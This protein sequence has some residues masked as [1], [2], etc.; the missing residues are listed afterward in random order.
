MLNLTDYIMNEATFNDLVES[1][2]D[3]INEC[4]TTKA[5]KALWRK[6][7]KDC[8]KEGLGIKA[9]WAD[10]MTT[11]LFKNAFGEVYQIDGNILWVEET[12]II[13]DTIDVYK[14]ESLMQEGL[15]K[16]NIEDRVYEFAQDIFN[17]LRDDINKNHVVVDVNG[18][19]FDGGEE[20]YDDMRDEFFFDVYAKVKKFV[21]NA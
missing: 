12:E 11:N 1:A 16:V 8:T 21:N 20:W 13:K 2:K 15:E 6:E 14:A 19:P 10:F 3:F 7:L 5:V 18:E 17:S 4:E 9:R